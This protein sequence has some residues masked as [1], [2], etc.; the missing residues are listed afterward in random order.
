MKETLHLILQERPLWIGTFG[1]LGTVMLESIHLVVG[2]AV[3]LTTIAY[4][5]LKIRKELRHDRQ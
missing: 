1:A 3:G 2:I 5:V 4:L